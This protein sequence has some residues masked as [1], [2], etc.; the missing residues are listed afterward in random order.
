MTERP[1][2][3]FL[4]LSGE[5]EIPD[6]TSIGGFEEKL[7][8]AGMIEVMFDKFNEFLRQ[9]GYEAKEGQIIDTKIVPVPIQ[10]NSREEYKSIKR[11]GENVCPLSKQS[12]QTGTK[13]Y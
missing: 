11:R 13:R 9:S 8:K 12:Q 4:G 5:A 6:A 2:R 7:Q 10:R 3:R 1:S